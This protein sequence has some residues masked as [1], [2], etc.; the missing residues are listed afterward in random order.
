MERHRTDPLSLLFGAVFAAVGLA[1]L[2]GW[3][4]VLPVRLH[5]LGPV[6]VVVVGL[7][8]LAAA[9]SRPDRAPSD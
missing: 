5:W 8:L 9:R 7:W 4:P 3:S 1:A 2:L 6:A